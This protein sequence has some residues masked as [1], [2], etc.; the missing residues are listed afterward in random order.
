MRRMLFPATLGLAHGVADG[1]AGLLLGSLLHTQTLAQ[2]GALVLF[3]NVLAFGAQPVCGAF[4]DRVRRPR[5]AVLAGLTLLACGLMLASFEVV[6]AVALAGIGSALF[7]VGGGAIALCATR[8]RAVGPGLFAAPGVVGLIAGG[9]LALGGHFHIWPFVVALLVLNLAVCTFEMP[10]L[11][12]GEPDAQFTLEGKELFLLG[13]LA[14][15]AL[16]SGV[17]TTV[18][19]ALEGRVLLLLALALAAGTGKLLGGVLA[20][21]CGWRRWTVGALILSAPLLAFGEQ[22]TAALLIG[23]ALLQSA[24]PATLAAMGQLLPQRPATAA[25]L[26]LGLGIAVG[27]LLL[28]GWL[29]PTSGTTLWPS[30]SL[31]LSALCLWFVLRARRKDGRVERDACDVDLS[32]ATGAR[33]WLSSTQRSA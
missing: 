12:E 8:G 1:A 24:T 19:F 20:D 15:I 6:A 13:L 9:A 4:V 5:V 32:G 29:S 30:V 33:A 23:I 2:T 14:A 25:G 16:R 21:R 3:Y 27:G 28:Y 22:S 26:A 7:H 11:P 17:W 18:Q 10:E 31:L